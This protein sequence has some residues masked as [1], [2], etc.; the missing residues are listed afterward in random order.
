MYSSTMNPTLLDSEELTL[1]LEL[2]A[3]LKH[4]YISDSHNFWAIDT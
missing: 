3:V 1:D 2:E 4:Q